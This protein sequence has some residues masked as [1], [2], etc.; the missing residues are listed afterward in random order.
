[1]SKQWSWVADIKSAFDACGRMIGGGSDVQKME[2][3]KS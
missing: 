1:M 3:P 2:I